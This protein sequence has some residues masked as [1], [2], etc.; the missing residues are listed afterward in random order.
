MFLGKRLK[1]GASIWLTMIWIY[2]YDLFVSLIQRIYRSNVGFS[3]L[4]LSVLVLRREVQLGNES[5][6]YSMLL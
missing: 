2:L 4:V 1:F 3:V 5:D 6:R